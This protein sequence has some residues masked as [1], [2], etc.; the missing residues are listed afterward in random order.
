M[1]L[2]ITG[3]DPFGGQPI[4]PSWEAVNALPDRIGRCQLD[5]L[6]IPTVFGAAARRVL[7]RAEETQP[8]LILSVGQAALRGAITPEQI[9]INLRRATLAD[10]AGQ[11]PADEPILPGG[12]DGLFSTL[13]VPEMARAIQATGIP[14]QVSYS[15][16]AFVCND[17]LYTLLHHFRGSGTGVGFVHVP[18]LPQQARPG[19][20]SLTLEQMVAGLTAAIEIL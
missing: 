5:K 17:V 15:A 4:N 8:D 1:R 7:A 2:L 20:A 11:Q 10:N 14:G 13:P 12:P 3:F 16:G 9:G 18:L 19:E 6:Q